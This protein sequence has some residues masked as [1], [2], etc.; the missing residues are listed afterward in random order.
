MVRPGV[1]D[2]IG[3]SNAGASGISRGAKPMILGGSRCARPHSMVGSPV[4]RFAKDTLSEEYVIG[5]DSGGQ[6]MWEGLEDFQNG[7]DLRVAIFAHNLEGSEKF[8]CQQLSL[9]STSEVFKGHE[10]GGGFE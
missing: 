2:C 1:L 4:D 5:D 7:I 10:N 8:S 3:S 6:V 9:L